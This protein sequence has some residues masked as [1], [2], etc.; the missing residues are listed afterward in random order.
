VGVN[1]GVQLVGNKTYPQIAD[2][3]MRSFKIL[4]TLPCDVF[5]G[6]HAA[7]YGM[8]EKYAKL[9][10]SETNPFID[11]AGYRTYLDTMEKTFLAKL[12]EQK[13]A[14]QKAP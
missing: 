8:Q 7:F 2:D 11:P 10:K 3:Y 14:Q 13:D 5:L 9:G 4:R 12:A 6:A 1:A